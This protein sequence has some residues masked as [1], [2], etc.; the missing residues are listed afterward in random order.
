ML[1]L[2]GGGGIFLG[3]I[4]R[5]QLLGRHVFIRS[6]EETFNEKMWWKNL[7]GRVVRG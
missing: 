5:R 6:W 4:E 7:D 2:L 1:V 3:K